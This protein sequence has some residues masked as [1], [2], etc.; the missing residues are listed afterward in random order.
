[1]SLKLVPFNPAWVNHDKIDI[2]AI[3][4]RPRFKADEFGEFDREY[5]ANGIPTWDLTGPLPIKQHNKWM[6]KGFEYVTL[7]DRASLQTAARFST[8][9]DDSGQPTNNWMQYDQHQSGGPWS[10]KKYHAGIQQTTTL[11]A[12]E[13]EAQVAKFGWEAVEAIRRSSDPNFRVP[14]HMKKAKEIKVS[15]AP[16]K[17]KEDKPKDD[18]K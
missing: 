16:E 8:L 3:Y 5:D 6:A 13:L 9:M 15:V 17:P 2:K 12:Q 11:A 4:R 10:Y 1:M 18:K 14:E 7:A